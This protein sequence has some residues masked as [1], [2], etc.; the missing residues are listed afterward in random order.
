MNLRSEF[1]L[2][3]VVVLFV[4]DQQ[5]AGVVVLC[6]CLISDT[7]SAFTGNHTFVGAADV[8]KSMAT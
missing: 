1:S 3:F 7:I 5:M 6:M 4:S 8:L 2:I